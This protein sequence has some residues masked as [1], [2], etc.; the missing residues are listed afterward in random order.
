MLDDPDEAESLSL[1][2]MT[3]SVFKFDRSAFPSSNMPDDYVLVIKVDD[4]VE[5]F[6]IPFV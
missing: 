6:K 2:A 4:G 3:Y 5:Q 1:E